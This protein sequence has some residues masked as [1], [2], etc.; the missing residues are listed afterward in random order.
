MFTDTVKMQ[1]I[2]STVISE[3]SFSRKSVFYSF[4]K[5]RLFTGF[6]FQNSL[7]HSLASIAS[8]Y[9]I[10]GRNYA[11]T[12]KIWDIFCKN[13]VQV[14]IMTGQN[15]FAFWDFCDDWQ[16]NSGS[17]ITS[18]IIGYQDAKSGIW[19]GGF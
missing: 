14:D 6:P 8:I 15:I 4:C 5:L 3:E 10:E 7:Q 2:L 19:F 18:T 13:F 17:R 1:N 12:K 16:K 11:V 9:S